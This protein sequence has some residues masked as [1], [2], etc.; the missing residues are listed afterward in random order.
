MKRRFLGEWVDGR[1]L[2]LLSLVA[3]SGFLAACGSPSEPEEKPSTAQIRVEGTTPVPLQL[4]VSTD[5]FQV[6]DAVTLQISEVV[7]SADTTFITLPYEDVVD[8][9][10]GG[11][12]LV[13]LTNHDTIPANVRLRVN[14]DTGQNP[15]DQAATMSE[16]GTLR[17]VFLFLAVIV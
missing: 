2:A 7:E 4:V 6:Q 16:G 8:L 9:G 12:V 10:V 15:Y 11:S 1:R 5:F 14:L 17:Y 3:M 13:G